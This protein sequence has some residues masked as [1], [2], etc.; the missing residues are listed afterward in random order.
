MS[1][2]IRVAETQKLPR[3]LTRVM[4]QNGLVIEED[5]LAEPHDNMAARITSKKADDECKF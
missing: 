1:T 5:D 4:Q 3:R 2:Y